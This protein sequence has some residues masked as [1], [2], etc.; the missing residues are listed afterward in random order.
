VLS[1]T[2]LFV[3]VSTIVSPIL[4]EMEGHGHCPLMPINGREN[5]S[6]AAST[7]PMLQVKDLRCGAGGVM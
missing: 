5:P 2:R 6:G 3:T 7:H 4:T 1:F